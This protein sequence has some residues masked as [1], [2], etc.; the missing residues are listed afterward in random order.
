[1]DIYPEFTPVLY[2]LYFH[3]NDNDS[4]IMD[5]IVV[6]YET[7][8]NLPLNTFYKRGYIFLGWKE[9]IND[10]DIDYLNG[11]TFIYDKANSMHLY[12]HWQVIE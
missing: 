9:D 11:D 10:D 8:V 2:D 5:S 3:G 1:M 4:G 7:Q 12:A 6:A